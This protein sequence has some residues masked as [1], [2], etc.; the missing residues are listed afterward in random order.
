[1]VKE[2]VIKKRGKAVIA[3]E[4]FLYLAKGTKKFKMKRVKIK[5]IRK[6]TQ[7]DP[8]HRRRRSKYLL[9]AIPN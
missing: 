8:N 7:S 6:K 3:C 1:M 5:R 2:N 4:L 9:A